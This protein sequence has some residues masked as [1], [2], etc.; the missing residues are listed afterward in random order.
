ML[1]RQ[2]KVIASLFILPSVVG[3]TLL[4]AVPFL[5]VIYNSFYST[6]VGSISL[7]K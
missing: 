4:T 5:N 3:T 6:A 7:V 1:K 2:D